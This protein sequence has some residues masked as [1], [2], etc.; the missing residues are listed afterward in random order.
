M[1]NI[2]NTINKKIAAAE[3]HCADNRKKEKHLVIKGRLYTNNE[4]PE[5]VAE[6]DRLTA[7]DLWLRNFLSAARNA[8]CALEAAARF[9]L[10]L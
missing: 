4:D 5:A 7:Q 1:E 10:E 8:V 3:K 2:I 9:E 6:Y